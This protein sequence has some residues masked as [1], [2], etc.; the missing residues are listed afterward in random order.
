[1]SWQDVRGWYEEQDDAP[2]PG[3]VELADLT[4]FECGRPF[5]SPA[6]DPDRFCSM[7]C[8]GRWCR[9]QQEAAPEP[10]PPA[11]LTTTRPDRSGRAFTWRT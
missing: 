7:E 4:C 9:R 6:A 1:M 3:E 10:Y 2:E 5:Q 8:D 11:E